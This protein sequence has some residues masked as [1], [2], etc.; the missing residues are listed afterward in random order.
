MYA[1]SSRV[2]SRPCAPVVPC[3]AAPANAHTTSCWAMTTIAHLINTY[4]YPTGCTCRP[5]QPSLL[6]DGPAWRRRRVLP[7]TGKVRKVRCT[8]PALAKTATRTPVILAL[9]LRADRAGVNICMGV[10]TCTR[11]G[12]RCKGVRVCG[13]AWT[14]AAP[15]SA[16][17]SAPMLEPVPQVSFTLTLGPNE[18]L[19]SMPLASA[20][21]TTCSLHGSLLPAPACQ[22]R[23]GLS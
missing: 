3:M 5:G 14:Y 11:W 4:P 1:V 20:L 12:T 22:G 6:E 10:T 23:S 13:G 7:C 15:V 18:V 2:R 19:R 9:R 17:A 16:R 8:R 21:L